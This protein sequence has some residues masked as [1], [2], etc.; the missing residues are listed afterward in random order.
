MRLGGHG[1]LERG[2]SFD[3][4]LPSVRRTS[5]RRRI[6]SNTASAAYHAV[7][8]FEPARR[9]IVTKRSGKGVALLFSTQAPEGLLAILA[10]LAW[11]AIAGPF[12]IL[13]DIARQNDPAT[14]EIKII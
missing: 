10:T 2:A 1:N 5:G 6:R 11:G 12:C 3:H 4:K 13:G 7:G 9:G 8:R 14:R